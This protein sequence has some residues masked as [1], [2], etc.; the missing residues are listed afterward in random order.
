MEAAVEEVEIGMEGEEEIVTETGMEDAVE[1]IALEAAEEV[2][3]E[4]GTAEIVE[5]GM[6]E[7]GEEDTEEGGIAMEAERVEED[8]AEDE[9]VMEAAMEEVAATEIVEE[10]TSFGVC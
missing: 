10:D 6:E 5:T 1:E 9:I 2:E 7:A 8:M 3:E 4:T